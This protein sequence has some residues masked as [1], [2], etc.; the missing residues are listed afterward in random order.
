MNENKTN[1]SGLIKPQLAFVNRGLFSDHFIQE[2]LPA[3]KEWGVDAELTPFHSKLKALFV[4]KKPFLA[5]MNEAQTEDEFVKPVLDLLGYGD[6]YIV[7]ASTKLGK[8]T[9][10]PDYA[11]FP[12]QAT[13]DKAYTKIKD[14]DY[15]QCIGIAD[16]KYWER[17]LDLAKSSERDTFTN[18]NPSFQIAGYLTGTKQNWGILTNGR[19]WRLYST[20]SHLPL[21]NYYQVDLVQLLEEAPAETLKYFYVFFRKE[22]LLR[23]DG[24]SFLDR[25]LEGSEEYAVELEA[26]IKDRAYDVVELLCRGFA[27]GFASEKVND[28]TLRSIY[29]NSLTLLYRLLFVFYAEARELLPLTANASYRDNY[30][31][32][33]LTH[34][35][36]DII[37]KDYELSSGSTQYYHQLNTLFNLID[38]GDSKLGV[39]EY[40]GGL[41]DPEEHPFLETHSIP[42]SHLVKAIHQLA[43][44]TDKKLKREVAVDYNTLSERHLGSI[45]EGLLEFRP[46]IAPHDLVVIKEKGSTKY[47]PASKQ[48]GKK[49]AYHKGELYLVN[50]KGERKASGSYYTPEYIVNYIVENTLDPLTKEAQAKVNALKPE[51]DKEIRK[52]QKLKEQKKGQE[53]IE[54]YTRAISKEREKLFGPYLSLK[55]LDPAMG[56]GHFLARATD[57]LAEKIAKDP[58]IE[59]PLELTEESELTYYRRRVV[60]SC[61]YGVDFNPLAVELAKLTLWLTTMAKSKPLSFLNHHLRAGNSLIGARIADLDEIPKAKGKKKSIDLT[62]APVQLGLFQ[63]VF[64]QKLYDLLQ[65]RAL[66]AKLPT[67]TLEDVHDK[68]KWEKAFEHNVERFLTLANVWT[69]TFFGNEVAWDS[70]NTLI[71]KL[72]IPDSE[73]EKLVQKKYVQKALESSKEKRFFHWELE[74]PEVFYDEQG[75]R[76]DDGG[77]DAVIGNPP[78]VDSE[79]MVI[80]LPEERAYISSRFLTAKGNWDLYVPFWELAVGQLNNQGNASLI[81][82]NKW[83]SIGYGKALRESV[84]QYVYRIGDFSAIRVFEDSGIFSVVTFMC[85]HKKKKVEVEVFGEGYSLLSQQTIPQTMLEDCQKWG[86]V[87]SYYLSLLQK[88][89]ITSQKLS[90]IATAEEAFTVSEAYEL[91]P[92]VHESEH[93]TQDHFKLVVTGTIDRYESLW[94]IEITTYLKNGYIHPV[95]DKNKLL[96]EFSKRYQ[97]A[98]SEKLVISG[99]R[100]FE[101]FFDADKSILAGKSTVIVRDFHDK[102]NGRALMTLLN[103][104]LMKF[105]IRES[106]GALAMDEGINFTA[107]LISEL[108]IRI[109]NFTTPTK[110]RKQLLDQFK[111]LYQ[112]YLKSKDLDKILAFTAGLLP[113]KE[114]ST[115]D[116]EQEHSNVVHDLLALLAEEMTRFNK[117]KQDKIKGFLTWLENEIIKGSIDDQKNKTKIKNF[118]EGTVEELIDV[119]KKNK[120]IEDPY[121]SSKWNTLNAEFS[122]AVSEIT[123]LKA[124]IN[125]TDKLI[126]Q[127]VY[128]LYNLSP[129]EIA[130]VEEKAVA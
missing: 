125:A 127:I 96:T 103:S 101:C 37:K 31:L 38:K 128:K 94:G 47:A 109:V 48:P 22:A 5:D 117:E 116:T 7:Q 104:K 106:Y 17:E 8:Q 97:Q 61:I 2:H 102:Y 16:A 89:W 32:R 39:P 100:H 57:F 80:N 75:G 25:V 34:I 77:F 88:I 46:Q 98:N 123:P 3:W 28:A 122:A 118:H 93:S 45:Y 27:A 64:N 4:A 13:K 112:N 108:P 56:S 26:D 55:V 35:I 15:T 83:V 6:S 49:I 76:K 67:E 92:L 81:T 111:K 68:Q 41:F 63:A 95:I 71:E 124:R 53:P 78:Y 58:N 19:L 130:I 121:P 9:S 60:E 114:D 69:S 115:P 52:W 65:N 73:W 42:D 54:K 87:F 110:E 120:V 99:I 43:R 33:R 72:Q 14:N 36:D 84:W 126:D 74:F 66:I 91:Q 82:P 90:N 21:G 29:D 18:L 79:N 30:S 85:K 20:K 23:V 113:V 11:L 107:P 119:L 12:D 50:D 44:I 86:M 1:D 70:Y 59:S 51:I 24:K 105:Y 129:D 62:R 40:N 10:R